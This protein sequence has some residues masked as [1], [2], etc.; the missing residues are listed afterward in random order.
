MRAVSRLTIGVALLAVASQTARAEQFVL[1][2]GVYTHADAGSHRT[3]TMAPGVPPNWKTPVD[4]TTGRTYFRLEVRKKPN[5]TTATAYQV[6]MSVNQ[7]ST[8]SA[9]GTPCTVAFMSGSQQP[10]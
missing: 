10:V 3:I 8:C 7:G 4:Y 9:M 1:F 5:D 6:C 2:D